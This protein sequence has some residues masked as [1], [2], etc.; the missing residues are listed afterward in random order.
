MKFA[1]ALLAVTAA[2][3]AED[4]KIDIL[5]G[6]VG[7]PCFLAGLLT[8]TTVNRCDTPVAIM[9]HAKSTDQE[10]TGFIITATFRE[11]D[12]KET[13]QSSVGVINQYGWATV[14]FSPKSPIAYGDQPG[15]KIVAI[16][17]DAQKRVAS[18]KLTEEMLK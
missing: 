15:T 2:L 10:V 6:P 12:G 9:V 11:M 5:Y 1:I 14:A 4:A 7:P 13:T 3:L 8:D 18:L 16:Q 17:A